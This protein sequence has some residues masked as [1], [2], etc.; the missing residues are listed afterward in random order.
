M[1]DQVAQA[2]TGFAHAGLGPDREMN[3]DA[4]RD[5]L[6]QRLLQGSHHRMELGIGSRTANQLVKRQEGGHHEVIL[7]HL[8]RLQHALLGWLP[9]RTPTDLADRGIVFPDPDIGDVLGCRGKH[10][11]ARLEVMG[12]GPTGY[13]RLLGDLLRGGLGIADAD[14]TLHGGIENLRAHQMAFLGLPTAVLRS[15]APNRLLHIAFPCTYRNIPI[16]LIVP[17]T[18]KSRGHD[19]SE[20]CGHVPC[21]PAITHQDRRIECPASTVTTLPLI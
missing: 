7:K 8:E 2:F 20:D 3:L 11:G 12:H 16:H 17:S 5:A 9:T 18:L 4:L 19:P 1:H 6:V 10:L 15:L 13:A 14:Q 21:S